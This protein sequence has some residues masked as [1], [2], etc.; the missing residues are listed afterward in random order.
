MRIWKTLL[1]KK[2]NKTVAVISFPG[3]DYIFMMGLCTALTVRALSKWGSD[4]HASEMQSLPNL[5]GVST[6]LYTHP[7]KEAVEANS[8]IS[9]GVYLFLFWND[10]WMLPIWQESQCQG[11]M[12]PCPVSPTAKKQSAIAS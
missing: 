4:L 7:D 3:P 11:S 10:T 5:T 9:N 8:V 2:Y 6:V 12:L 1:D